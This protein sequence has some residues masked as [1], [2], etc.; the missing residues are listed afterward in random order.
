MS[1]FNINWGWPLVLPTNA[2]WEDLK[3]S[4]R[5]FSYIPRFENTQ[6]EGL[7]NWGDI[8]TNLNESTSGRN[9]WIGKDQIVEEIISFTLMN[10]LSVFDSSI[11]IG[12]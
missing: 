9:T 11:P 4:Y 2:T 12:D 3:Q 1:S 7:V 10:G 5:F 6:Y 8:I